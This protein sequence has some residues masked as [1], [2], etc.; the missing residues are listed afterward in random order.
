[1]TRKELAAAYGISRQT[2]RRRLREITPPLNPTHLVLT[3]A[4]LTRIYAVLGTPK[5]VQ[6]PR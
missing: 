1:M 5:N 6:G 3:P 2:L 4:E